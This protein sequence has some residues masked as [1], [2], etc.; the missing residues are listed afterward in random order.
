MTARNS[1]FHSALL[2]S[3]LSFASGCTLESSA[4]GSEYSAAIPKSESVRIAAP[5]D[6]HDQDTQSAQNP[7]PAKWYDY[8]RRATEDLNEATEAVVGTVHFVA[9]TIP[10]EVGDDFAVWGPFTLFDEPGSWRLRIDRD[11]TGQYDYEFSGRPRTSTTDADFEVVL[12]GKGYG[13]DDERHGDGEFALHI[14]VARAIN[15]ERFAQGSGNAVFSHDLPANIDEDRTATPRTLSVQIDPDGDAWG[16]FTSKALA[17]GS[18]ELEVK[19]LVDTDPGETALEDAVVSSKWRADG[20]GRADVT[21][22][23]GDT[24]GGALLDITECWARDASR[25]YYTDSLGI[26]PV[27]GAPSNCAM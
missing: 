27:F 18:A 13:L 22:S 16:Q 25:V 7:S 26:E 10:T 11:A 23:G 24:V 2:V 21:V 8:T 17:D 20:A 1:V 9:H 12:E 14:D 19:G 5:D 4:D 3:V 15:P 6:A